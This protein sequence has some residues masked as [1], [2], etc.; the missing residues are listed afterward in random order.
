MHSPA[1]K[2]RRCNH[3]RRCSC[4]VG[5]HDLQARLRFLFWM[6]LGQYA[7]RVFSCPQS[8]HVNSECFMG[9]PSF[10][11]SPGRPL[12]GRSL[13]ARGSQS[14]QL[15][16]RPRCGQSAAQNSVLAFVTLHA[17]HLCIAA[18][19]IMRCAT[20][21]A[22]SPPSVAPNWPLRILLQ[23]MQRAQAPCGSSFPIKSA[24]LRT[25]KSAMGFMKS[26]FPEMRQAWGAASYLL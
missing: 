3:P 1:R 23:A 13:G 26:H 18:V 8:V 9:R 15:M 10:G 4:G 19:A 2:Y 14:M 11:R 17:A 6:S 7:S 5:W 24:G 25:P 22:F 21:V 20:L 12:R 16:P